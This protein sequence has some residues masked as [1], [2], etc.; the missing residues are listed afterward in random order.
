MWQTILANM[1]FNKDTFKLH[2]TPI[3]YTQHGEPQTFPT[4]SNHTVRLPNGETRQLKLTKDTTV[5]VWDES[6]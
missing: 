4:H 3:K 6:K 1:L 2:G 5:S